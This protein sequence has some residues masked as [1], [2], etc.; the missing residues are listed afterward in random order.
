VKDAERISKI[1]DPKD[2]PKVLD[3][4]ADGENRIRLLI[5]V[6]VRRSILQT[7]PSLAQITVGAKDYTG[8]I[9]RM[10]VPRTYTVNGNKYRP[11]PG[12][13]V[14]P[15][16]NMALDIHGKVTVREQQMWDISRGQESQR[17][18]GT[19][20]DMD[21]WQSTVEH[22]SQDIKGIDIDVQAA[23]RK[24]GADTKDSST[25]EK[26]IADAIPLDYDLGGVKVL[27]NPGSLHVLGMMT[28][29]GEDLGATRV[30]NRTM[31]NVKDGL[32]I[33]YRALK[34]RGFGKVWYGNI[35][36][37]P[38]SVASIGTTAK[39]GQSFQSGGHYRFSDIVVLNPR[40]QWRADTIAGVV[41]HE[42]GHR[43]WY[44]FMKAG[45]R[46]RFSAW[47]DPRSKEDQERDGA[48]AD[49]VPAPTAY[50]AES[51][52]E[53]FAEV[54]AAYVLGKYEGITL[55]GPQ[56]ARFEALALG[57]AAQSESR[58][59]ILSRMIEDDGQ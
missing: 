15:H 3:W 19:T 16:L 33:G 27:T 40:S 55:T 2:R 41:V 34:Q 11:E 8:G 54:F 47:F 9:I 49:F 26:H 18:W 43:Y 58:L 5:D 4:L 56:K 1:R 45:A 13:L 38:P 59:A 17:R 36:V 35:F 29:P 32:E 25:K 10:K 37:M 14:H 39:T 46:A 48:Q 51:A 21:E 31:I 6:L 23:L 28:D 22:L 20:K 30:S 52:V 42:L 7:E 57:R 50:G 53:E 24:Y 44:K 12:E